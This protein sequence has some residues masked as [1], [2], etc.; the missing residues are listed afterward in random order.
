MTIKDPRKHYKTTP[1]LV[2]SCQY[3]VIWCPKYRRK[4]LSEAIQTRLKELIIS[5]QEALDFEVLEMETMSDHVH[6]ALDVAY[7]DRYTSRA[8]ERVY[9]IR[10]TRGISRIKE[11][12]ALSVDAE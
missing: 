6:L 4:V 9:V 10:I 7:W 1:T 12:A 3:H 2:Y 5:K 8:A 11:T